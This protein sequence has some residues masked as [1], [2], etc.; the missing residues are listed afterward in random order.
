MKQSIKIGIIQAGAVYLDLEKSMAKAVDLMGRAVEKGAELV[1]FGETWL[2]GY[3]AW[4]DHCPEVGFWNHEPV[5]EVFAQMIKSSVVV[6]GKE[7]GVFCDFARKQHVVIV[8]GVNETVH[9]G[10]GNGTIYNTQLTIAANG[11]IVNHHR[12]LMPTFTEKLLY[13]TGDGYGLKASETHL[14]RIGGLI[15]WEHWMPLARQA[16]HH[17]GE[18]LHIALW[19]WVH[20]LHQI[21]SRH[22][23]FE[24][25]CIVVAVGQLMRVKDFPKELKLPPH[26]ENKPG[27]LILKGGSCIFAPDGTYILEPQGATEEVIVTEITGLERIYR[28]RLTLDTS[29]HYYRPDV[30]TFNVNMKRYP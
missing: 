4:L 7:T 3:P 12:K 23:A 11:E 29:G 13:A 16:L 2:S 21:A 18:H 6:P 10:P 5:K 22:Y 28:E 25:R 26:L 15:C 8:L 17:S 27:E 24:G 19:P 30:F 9:S 20:D 14:G 1:V